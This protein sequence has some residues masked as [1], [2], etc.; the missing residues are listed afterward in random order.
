MRICAW[1]CI[2][3]N[4]MA[5]SN[6]YPLPVVAFLAFSPLSGLLMDFCHITIVNF[7]T[8]A[9]WFQVLWAENRPE[10]KSLWILIKTVIKVALSYRRPQH[11]HHQFIIITIIIRKQC[12]VPQL[13]DLWFFPFDTFP[14]DD[15]WSGWPEDTGELSAQYQKWFP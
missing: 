6:P 11:H 10:Q 15:T 2:I 7:E 1:N 12:N 14:L 8:W 4:R 5:N 13:S 3:R 9:L